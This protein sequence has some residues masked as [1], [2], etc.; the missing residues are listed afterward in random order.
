MVPTAHEKRPVLE[1]WGADKDDDFPH[2]S[3]LSETAKISRRSLLKPRSSATGPTTTV[4]HGARRPEAF[5]QVD[6][7]L[8]SEKVL[9]D[10]AQLLAR[11]VMRQ[12]P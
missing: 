7:D 6:N 9:L 5:V 12:K 11:P 2:L 10:N 4:R 8:Q 1:D 3:R